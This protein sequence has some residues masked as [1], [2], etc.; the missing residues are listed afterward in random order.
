[1]TPDEF[2][3]WVKEM[4]KAKKAKSV[5]GIARLL[6]VDFKTVYSMMK[7]GGSVRDKLACEALLHG[8]KGE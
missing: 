4:L 6:G 2:N 3:I 1:M 5:R 8:I 7:R